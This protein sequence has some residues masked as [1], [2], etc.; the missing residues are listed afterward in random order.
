MKCGS[1][2][3]DAPITIAHRVVIA[4]GTKMERAVKWMTCVG[5]H[6]AEARG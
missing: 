6:L 2:G 1:C 4:Q 5:Y 3:L